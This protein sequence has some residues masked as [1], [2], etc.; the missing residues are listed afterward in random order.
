MD[1]SESVIKV[2]VEPKT[3]ADQQ[4]K[5]LKLK[6]NLQLKILPSHFPVMKKLVIEFAIHR[7]INSDH[8]VICVGIN[9]VSTS[10]G[11]FELV[12]RAFTRIEDLIIFP[13]F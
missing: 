1:F 2:A 13:L 10:S 11:G 7:R 8:C 4:Q 12:D 5:C 6:S 3:K 9:T